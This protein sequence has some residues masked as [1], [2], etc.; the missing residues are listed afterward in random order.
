MNCK[1]CNTELTKNEKICPC[2]GRYLNN[3]IPKPA[4]RKRSMWLGLGIII[5]AIIF[6]LTTFGGNLLTQKATNENLE[7]QVAATTGNHLGMTFDKFKNSFNDNEYTKK[8]GL[9]IGNVEMVK[10]NGDSSFQ[11]VFNDKLLINGVVG[12]YDYKLLEIRIIGQ[13]SNAEDDIIKLVTAMGVLIDLFSPDI[14]MNKRGEILNELG[15]NQDADLYKA[16]NTAIRGDKKYNLKFVDQV[17]F[18]FSVNHINK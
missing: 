15:F 4:Y 8:I 10:S 13:P 6:I 3:D 17:G 16:S 1:Y 11:Y 7:K 18:I 12:K 2:C 9:N 5:I 14:P